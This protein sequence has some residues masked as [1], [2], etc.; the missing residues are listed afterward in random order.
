MLDINAIVRHVEPLLRRLIGEDVSLV[1]QLHARL[2]AVSADPSQLEQVLLNLAVNA[3]DA[4]PDGG[5]LLVQ[6][7]N[8]E[9][10]DTAV[11]HHPGVMPGRYALLSVTDTGTGMDEA[12]R[13]RLF[14][15]FFTT[16]EIGKGTGL[17]LATVYGIVRQSAGFIYVYSEPGLGTTFKVYFPAIEE[18]APGFVPPTREP[19]FVGGTE[20]VLLVEDQPELRMVAAEI[21]RRH[22]YTVLEAID[23]E[24]AVRVAGAAGGAID[25]LLTD[26]VMPGRGGR[27]LAASLLALRPS[28]RVVYMSGYA[29][30]TMLRHGIIDGELNFIQK[31]FSASSLLRKMREVLDSPA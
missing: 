7:A 29:D 5:R 11:A 2:Q 30:D 28:M 6:T 3:R 23:G 14:E 19:A 17:G 25:A 22:G 12:T 24:E 10:D 15:P 9:L 1:L 20:T 27:V 26:V 4:M 16:K 18:E 8:V 21:L 31:P 13:Q